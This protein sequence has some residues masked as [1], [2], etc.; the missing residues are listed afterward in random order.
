MRPWALSHRASLVVAVTLVLIGVAR[1]LTDTLHELDHDY[2]RSLESSWLRYLVRAPSDGTTLG[3]L[4]AQW[5]K[6]LSVPAGISLIYLRSRFGAGT[7]E[8]REAEFRDWAVS[9]V[10]IVMFWAG[11]TVIEVQ[12]QFSPW[13][14][15]TRLVAGEDPWLNHLVHLLS[16]GLAWR[17]TR[18]LTIA[19]RGP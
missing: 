18:A 6:L 2:W 8:E 16:A 17:L 3:W 19:P 14:F 13:S 4:N 10:W 15:S 7:D 1:S 9:G 5:F 11:F 12:K